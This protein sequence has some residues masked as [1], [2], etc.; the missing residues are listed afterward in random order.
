M[1]DL[2]YA[3]GLRDGADFIISS[4]GAKDA[5]CVP[6]QR[7]AAALRKMADD[8]EAT[9]NTCARCGRDARTVKDSKCFDK[10]CPID[11]DRSAQKVEHS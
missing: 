10:E 1:S 9:I 7:D 3:D 11:A 6:C 5:P 8:Y 2:T 4:C